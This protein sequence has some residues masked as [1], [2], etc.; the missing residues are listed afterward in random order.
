MADISSTKTVLITEATGYIGRW[1]IRRAGLLVINRLGEKDFSS[2]LAVKKSVAFSR[3]RG[4]YLKLLSPVARRTCFRNASVSDSLAGTFI[5]PAMPSLL[6]AFC[7]AW[8][9]SMYR[10]ILSQGKT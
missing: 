3:L 7:H 10:I 2:T 5:L 9:Y 8:R 1:L 6:G 4:C